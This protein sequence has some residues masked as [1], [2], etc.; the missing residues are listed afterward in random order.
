MSSP[1][2][3]TSYPA[4]M[5]ISSFAQPLHILIVEQDDDVRN[6][7]E[8]LFVS[9]GYAVSCARHPAE[10]LELVLVEMPDVIFSS[11][12]FMGMHGFE[13]CR[14]L[15]AL[16]ETSDK[17]IVALTGYSDDNIETEILDA[18]FDKYLPKPVSLEVL[19]SLLKPLESDRFKRQS[20]L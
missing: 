19:L 16:P 9:Q 12:V 13:L 2:V 11:L 1:F 10:A 4:R 3:H 6:V 20:E 8:M 5:E 15:R 7:F 18:G 14:R 17:F